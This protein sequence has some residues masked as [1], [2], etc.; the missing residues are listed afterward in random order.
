MTHDDRGHYAAKHPPGTVVRP[1]IQQAV[2][3]KLQQGKIACAVAHDI[4]QSLK[5]PPKEIGMAIDLKEG[6]IVKCQLGLYGYEPDGK[7][8]HPADTIDPDVQNAIETHAKDG[9]LSCAT[10]W[11][12]AAEHGLQRLAFSNVCE[13]MGIKIKPCQLGAF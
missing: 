9:R 10:A 12:L 2:N 6:S 7:K 1:E 11:Q 5:V 3:E 4:A 8:V 13:A